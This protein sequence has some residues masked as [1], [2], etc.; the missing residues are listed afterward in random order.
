LQKLGL[1]EIAD[2]QAPSSYYR[3]DPAFKLSCC[4][5]YFAS[6]L[7]LADLRPTSVTVEL[8]ARVVVRLSVRPSITNIFWLVFGEHFQI[9]VWMKVV[10]K[11]CIFQR[12]T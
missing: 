9:W 12:K 8:L 2:S 7:L 10:E 3:D 5:V 6:Q 4:A 1:P 11:M